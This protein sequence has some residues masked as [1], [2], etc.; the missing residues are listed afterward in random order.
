MW[1]CIME[2]EKLMLYLQEAYGVG[3]G[4]VQRYFEVKQDK[5]ILARHEKQHRI[6]QSSGKKPRWYTYL[7]DE[8]ARKGLRLVVKTKREDLE[9]VIVAHY[10]SLEQEAE[11]KEFTLESLYDEWLEYKKAETNSSTYP[12]RIDCDF[13]RFY[14]GDRIVRI[15]LGK[16]DALTIRK[17]YLEMVK[18]HS[19]TKKAF[20]NMKVIMRQVLG[21]ALQKHIIENNP[22]EAIDMPARLFHP[23]KEHPDG[24]QVFNIEEKPQMIKAAFADFEE[25]GNPAALAV[26]F[27]FETGLRSSEVLALKFSDIYKDRPYIHVCRT[28]I[29]V[30]EKDDGGKWR[31]YGYQVV[32]HTKT[33]AGT[34]DVY[35]TE[36]AREILK[37]AEEWNKANGYAKAEY[38]F[39]TPDKG[40][41]HH[42]QIDYRIK[43]YCRQNGVSSR[44]V[45]KIR[46]TFISIL[47]DDREVPVNE[48]RRMVGHKDART[49][50]NNYL[51]ST[52][53]NAQTERAIEEALNREG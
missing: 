4:D 52:R 42:R 6:W 1:G 43:K 16:L 24:T 28:E 33:D 31:Q 38:I 47:I 51:R 49:T 25:C 11:E 12:A 10:K 17:W 20:N 5:E 44:S 13:R 41:A 8:T 29:R 26:A 35:L 45:H 2:E 34:R 9:K 37:M 39:M 22:A 19:L 7:P 46:K 36:R 15:P 21:Y 48:I 18:K 14:R 40:K 53:T 30:E 27:L 3:V 50:Y 23:A 32:S